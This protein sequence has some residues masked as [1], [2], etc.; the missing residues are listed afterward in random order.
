MPPTKRQKTE[1]DNVREEPGEDV[2]DPEDEEASSSGSEQAD[3]EGGSSPDTDDGIAEGMR[4]KS[5]KTQKRKRRA[6]DATSFGSALQSLLSTNAPSALPLSLKPSIARQRNDEKLEAKG[7]KIIQ[8]E[9]K[10]KEEKGR[11]KDVI[12]GWGGESERA[13][14]KVAQRGVVKLFNVI[15]QSQATGAAAEEGLKAQRGSGKPTLPAPSLAKDKTRGGKLKP[16]A[17]GQGKNSV[18]GEDD[19]LNSIRSGGVVSKA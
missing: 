4:S 5:R 15:Q 18:V 11:V 16:N 1:K 13:L 12:G 3:S 14:R 6:T 19:F 17:L 7:K 8:V 2:P 9:R 10:E